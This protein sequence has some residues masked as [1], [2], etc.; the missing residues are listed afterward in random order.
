M[1]MPDKLV[2]VS[3]GLIAGHGSLIGS[4]SAPATLQTE[5]SEQLWPG[6]IN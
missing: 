5:Y 2:S 6:P 4:R 3:Q 1:S